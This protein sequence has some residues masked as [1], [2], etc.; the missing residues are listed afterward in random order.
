M[1]PVMGMPLLNRCDLAAQMLDS[2]QAEVGVT[3]VVL[4]GDAVAARDTLAGRGITYIEPG[5]NLGVAA[6]W[7]MIIRA[8]PAA[9]WW[10]IVNA[11]IIL[12]S[13]DVERLVKAMQDPAAQVACLFEFGAFAINQ[14]AIDRVGWFDENFY[15]I[16]FEDNDYRRR[17]QM[18]GVP[19][20]NLISRTRH[21][22]S[23]TIASGY[24]SH[25]ARTFP[26][27]AAYYAGKWGG[28]P[29]HETRTTPPQVT[30]DRQRLVNNA[31]T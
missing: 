5:H 3:L 14:A 2:V 25:N 6:S 22:N 1:I 31:W 4:N 16:Y 18:A 17:C 20:R 13:G 19:I 9:P 30:L 27:N 15:P 29:G 10:F 21:F 7:N 23:S 24:A 28:P 8:R 12:G 11:D 26:E